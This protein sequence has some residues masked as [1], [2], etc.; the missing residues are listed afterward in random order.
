MCFHHSTLEQLWWE[1][2]EIIDVLVSNTV[3]ESVLMNE[4]SR[5]AEVITVVVLILDW[6]C[7][8]LGD[9]K[10]CAGHCEVWGCESGRAVTRGCW[11]EKVN[12]L[13][14]DVASALFSSSSM[15]LSH[16]LRRS[17]AIWRASLPHT[18]RSRTWQKWSLIMLETVARGL[19]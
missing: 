11:Y 10:Y 7:V 8:L 19:L 13:C 5:A 3:S 4:L 14:S 18:C 1:A 6:I 17:V 15:W 2:W 9:P 12:V 16:T